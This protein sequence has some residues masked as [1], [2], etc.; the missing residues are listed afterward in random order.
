M[1]TLGQLVGL[2]LT[3]FG[4]GAVAVGAWNAFR[5]AFQASPPSAQILAYAGVFAVSVGL[6]VMWRERRRFIIKSL[7]PVRNDYYTGVMLE[8]WNLGRRA[9]FSGEARWLVDLHSQPT[10]TPYPLKWDRTNKDEKVLQPNTSTYLD[11]LRLRHHDAG[12]VEA[13]PLSVGDINRQIPGDDPSKEVT[14][15]DGYKPQ[16]EVTIQKHESGVNKTVQIAFNG[17]GDPYLV[18]SS[19]P[20]V[21]DSQEPPIGTD[22]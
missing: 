5:E 14:G 13:S 2:V 11:V 4:V 7:I 21:P 15:R 1:F 12:R 8:V 3:L 20:P 18:G 17:C 22:E 10:A 9:T 16:F 6:W 19:S